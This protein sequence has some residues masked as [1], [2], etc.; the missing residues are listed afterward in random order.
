MMTT[1][2]DNGS[3]AVAIADTGEGIKKSDLDRLF[4]P[5][6]TTKP[7]SGTGLGLFVSQGIIKEHSGTIK[8]KSEWGKGS[9]FTVT[10]PTEKSPKRK[11]KD[12]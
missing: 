10:L 9:V 3:V 11:P 5:F 8:V 4:E 6:F 2:V 12:R 1:S 7:E